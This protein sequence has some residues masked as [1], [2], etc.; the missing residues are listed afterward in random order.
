[1]SGDSP[2]S[3]WT[4]LFILTGALR[5]VTRISAKM[6]SPILWPVMND[7]FASVENGFLS[8]PTCWNRYV[9]LWAV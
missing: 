9:V 3:D 7:W 2:S 5:L 1:M 4:Q 6:S 8:T